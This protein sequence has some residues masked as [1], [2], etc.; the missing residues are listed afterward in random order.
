MKKIMLKKLIAANAKFRQYY[1][2]IQKSLNHLYEKAILLTLNK[3]DAI[4]QNSS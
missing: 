4:F 1:A 2:K 3:K